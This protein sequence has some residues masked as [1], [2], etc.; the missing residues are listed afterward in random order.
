NEQAFLQGEMQGITFL[1]S[2]GDDGDEVVASGTLQA[3]YPA[4]DPYVLSVGGTSTGIGSDGSLTLLTGWGTNKYSLSADGSSWTPVGFLYGSG[5]GFSSLFNRPSYQDGVVPASA[6]PG[7]AVPDVAMNADPN[8]GM[9]IGET[10]AF[11]DGNKY[12]EYRIGGTSLASPLFTGMQALHQQTAGR[13][14][15]LNPSLYAA[16]RRGTTA[17]T[18]V[19]PVHTGDGVVRPDY[20]NSLDPSGGLTYSV[21]TFN[22]DS[23]LTTARGWDDVTGIGVPSPAYVGG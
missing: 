12:G 15:L 23:S 21:R 9:L 16:A 11:P 13:Q 4:S 7:R 3:D 8:T 10:Q 22:Q 14:G 18:D 1:F 19:R 20:V 17:F 6:P 5:G 2:S